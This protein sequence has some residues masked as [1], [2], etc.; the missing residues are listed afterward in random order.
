MC[1]ISLPVQAKD[2]KVFVYDV[3]AGGIHAVEASITTDLSEA[4]RYSIFLGA[5]TRGF[6]GKMAPWNGVFESHGWVEKD[7]EYRPQLH[8][9][10]ATW[11]GD[12]EVKSYYYGRDRSFKGLELKKH[13]KPLEKREVSDELTQGATDALSA[14][15]SVMRDVAAGQVCAGSEDVFDGKRRFKQVFRSEGTE[16][17]KASKYNVFG[18]EAQVC[19]VEVVPVVGKWHEKPR[20]WMSIQEQ[21]RERGT[22]PTVWMGMVEGHTVA[23]PVKIRVK[24]DYGT[25]FMHLTEYVVDG[26]A[27]KAAKR[28]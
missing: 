5:E 15:L 2:V 9:S 7:G 22:M 25:L 10:T 26:K 27:V 17:L 23:L 20:G 21:G 8:R 12:E 6:L 24:T 13:N 14:T 19:T 18:G 16:D 28:K 11:K 3:Y 1:L 4:G